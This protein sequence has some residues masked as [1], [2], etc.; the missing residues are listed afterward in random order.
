MR[1]LGGLYA[2]RVVANREFLANNPGAAR[3]FELAV[4]PLDDIAAQ[5]QL[6]FAGENT[7][8]DIRRHAQTWIENNRPLV[9]GW[10]AA[11]REAT[12]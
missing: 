12:K 1:K 2:G 10:L 3:L 6:Q 9:D 11:A 8:D 5:N 7:P 4:I